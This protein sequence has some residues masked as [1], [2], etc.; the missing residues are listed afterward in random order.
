MRCRA[1]QQ[2]PLS[3]TVGLMRATGV[4]RNGREDFA[5][6]G[7]A[8]PGKQVINI[9]T[10]YMARNDSRCDACTH[11]HTPLTHLQLQTDKQTLNLIHGE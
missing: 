11:T 5:L 2:Q 7:I 9:S 4:L 6:K 1:H 8:I 3:N 10:S